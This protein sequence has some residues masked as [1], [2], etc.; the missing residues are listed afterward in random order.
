MGNLL[1]YCPSNDLFACLFKQSFWIDKGNILPPLGAD[2]DSV[3]LFG[4]SSGAFMATQ[5]HISFPETFK[6]VAMAAGGPYYGFTIYYGDAFEEV[7]WRERSNMDANEIFNLAVEKA[8]LRSANGDIGDLS[9]IK[10]SPVYIMSGKSD[11]TVPQ[12]F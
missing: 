11:T 8:E 1:G 6:G 7:G 2:P 4:F 9:L 3:T 5:L 10:N 12:N